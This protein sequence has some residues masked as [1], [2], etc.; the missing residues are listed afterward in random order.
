MIERGPIRFIKPP[1]F[2]E[3]RDSNQLIRENAITAPGGLCAP[4][5]DPYKFLSLTS[6]PIRDA[7]VEAMRQSMQR[8]LLTPDE[9]IAFDLAHRGYAESGRPDVAA[10]LCED[11]SWDDEDYDWDYDSSDHVWDRPARPVGMRYVR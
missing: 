5:A 11:R 4:V 1:D 6:R 8:Q 3:N 10:K 9:R 2:S 7:F